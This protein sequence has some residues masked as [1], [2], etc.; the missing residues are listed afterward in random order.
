MHT[1]TKDVYIEYHSVCPLVGIETLPP[2]L[3]QSEWGGGH[4]RQGAMG[5]G[6]SNSDD[7][8]KSLALSAY[9][10]HTSIVP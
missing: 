4:T 6:S 5:W 2:P 3:P 1:S 8:R 7:W 9:S 10:V